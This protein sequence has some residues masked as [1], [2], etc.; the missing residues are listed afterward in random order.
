MVRLII[1]GIIIL[2]VLML[3]NQRGPTGVGGGGAGTRL[4]SGGGSALV[5]GYRS[6]PPTGPATTSASG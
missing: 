4:T 6:D 1:A 5:P 2:A 3:F